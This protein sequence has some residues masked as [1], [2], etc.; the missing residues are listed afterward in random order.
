VA[1][2]VPPKEVNSNINLIR[3]NNEKELY[4]STIK[5]LEDKLREKDCLLQK[6][7][8]KTKSLEIEMEEL[9]A[10]SLSK[11]KSKYCSL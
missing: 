10:T 1:K 11:E 6:A 3:E 5:N 7:L 2:D 4:E 8:D 9:K